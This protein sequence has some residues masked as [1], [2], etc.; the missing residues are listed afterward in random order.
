MPDLKR[1]KGGDIKIYCDESCHLEHDHS[2]VMVLGA[3]WAETGAAAKASKRLI[4]LK[5]RHGLRPTFDLKWVAVAPKKRNFFIDVVDYFFDNSNLMFRCVVIPDKSI[6]DHKSHDQTHDDWYYKMLFLLLKQIF[7]RANCYHVFL[8]IKDTRSAQKVKKLHEVI[9]NSMLDF[10]SSIVRNVQQVRSHEVQLLQM[11]DLLL[12]A[13]GY[14]NRGLKT[15]ETK[16]AVVQRI[17]E[18]SG[19]TLLKTTLPTERKFN[20]LSWTSSDKGI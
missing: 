11:A 15:S 20:V 5:K 2:K 6:L 10:D 7:T 4:E 14:A 18:R 13:V 9:A 16:L 17:R 12:G 19:F 1:A 3:I 8:D